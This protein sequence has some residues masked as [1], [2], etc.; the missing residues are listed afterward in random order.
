MRAPAVGP[1]GT[2][3]PATIAEATCYFPF[4]DPLEAEC[5]KVVFTKNVA[6]AMLYYVV[7]EK[8]IKVQFFS[9]LRQFFLVRARNNSV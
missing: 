1:T 6:L 5:E 8:F 2:P 3:P 7:S 4:F 9:F